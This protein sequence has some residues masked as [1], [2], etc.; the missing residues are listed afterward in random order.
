MEKQFVTYEIALALKELGFNEPCFGCWESNTEYYIPFIVGYDL[1][2]PENFNAKDNC[3]SAP[4]WQQVIEWLE[5]EHGIFI[6]IDK[7]KYYDSYSG[8]YT[9]QAWCRMY[10]DR[11]LD[12]SII[13]R[14]SESSNSTS[15]I[16]SSYNKA[17]EQ[18]ILKTIELIKNK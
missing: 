15:F 10:K 11:E 12:N 17:R 7:G 13:V 2:T 14:D 3:I 5:E 4:L 8:S 6:F 1:K 9:Y 16:F 18:S